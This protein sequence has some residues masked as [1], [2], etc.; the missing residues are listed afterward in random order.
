MKVFVMSAERK[1]GVSKR[2]NNPY[3]SVIVE[4]VYTGTGNKLV[5]KQ[6]WIDPTMLGGAIPQYGDVLD[7]C[8]GFSGFID[9][10]KFIASEKCALSVHPVKQQ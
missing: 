6:L 10:V 7:V 9:S 1:S 2:T 5:V 8:V 4:A 3:D